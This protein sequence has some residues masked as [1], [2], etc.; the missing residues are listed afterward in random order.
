MT[1]SATRF[2]SDSSRSF[3]W[4][5][6]PVHDRLIGHVPSNLI[7]DLVLIKQQT[8]NPL[9]P[10]FRCPMFPPSGTSKR[11]QMS[12]I[13][14]KWPDS[15]NTPSGTMAWTWECQSGTINRRPRAGYLALKERNDMDQITNVC[16][17]PTIAGTPIS[18]SIS[19]LKTS[20]TVS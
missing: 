6:G 13:C 9:A 16:T 7:I 2:L 8:E 4:H 15:V 18:P 11:R 3:E 1:I 5:Q 12:G 14:T 17:V 10:E 20:Q 19:S